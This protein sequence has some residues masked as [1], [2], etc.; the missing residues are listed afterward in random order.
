VALVGSHF[1]SITS[2]VFIVS[3]L[4]VAALVLL[5]ARQCDAWFASRFSVQQFFAVTLLTAV[6]LGLLFGRWYLAPASGKL[7]VSMPGMDMS[8]HG[9]SMGTSPSAE[10]Y[11]LSVQTP[12]VIAPGKTVTFA[13][14]VFSAS[15]GTPVTDFTLVH[16]RLAHLVIVNDALNYYSHVHP[17][18]VNGQFTVQTS[19]PQT[20]S[21]RAYISFEPKGGSEQVF[22]YTFNAG[23]GSSSK[24]NKTV[25][26]SSSKTVSGISIGLSP[27]QVSAAD[28]ASGKAYLTFRFTTASGQ[29]VTDIYPYLAAFGH[30]V[31]INADTYSYLHVHPLVAPFGPDETG[32]PD[33]KFMVMGNVEPGVYKLFGQFNPHKELITVPFTIEVTK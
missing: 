5:L 27:A 3:S 11:T 13:F 4:L 2:S 10:K 7:P 28:I 20:D 29:P 15:T 26:A 16:D 32:G 23:S 9:M 12:E 22:A 19:F 30:L 18:F 6:C 24:P 17:D 14:R 25:D 31:M 1:R 33:V 21:Y 8:M